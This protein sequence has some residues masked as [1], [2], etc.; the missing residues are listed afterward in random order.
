MDQIALK[1]EHRTG[2]G[3]QAAKHMRQSGLLPAVIYGTGEA[4]IP[5]SVKLREMETLLHTTGRNAI[6]NLTLEGEGNGGRITLMKEIQHH[7]IDRRLLHVDFQHI[8][9]TQKIRRE[10]SVVAAGM[11]VG[12]RSEGGILEHSLHTVEVECLPL[13]IPEKIEVDVTGL[14]I[15][16]SL[17]VRDL[18]E[19][20]SRIITDPER[21]VF[22]VVPPTVI[23]ESVPGEVPTTE[24][25]A[26]EPEL[27]VERGKKEEDEEGEK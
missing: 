16:K 24:E 12:V 22:L 7:P 9:L 3:K 25:T 11:P 14:G 17:H 26:K 15:N 23:K 21:L 13:E 2:L 6:V 20:D 27:S 5:I 8:S 10:V 4:P 19:I 18:L 1:G